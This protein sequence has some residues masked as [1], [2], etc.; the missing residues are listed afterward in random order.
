A[1]RVQLRRHRG[2]AGRRRAHG[3]ALRRRRRPSPLRS[4]SARVSRHLG[5]SGVRALVT[6]VDGVLTDGGLYF[7]EHGDE[8]KRF[9]VR[10]GQG[11]VLLREAGVLVAI[12]TRMPST[13]VTR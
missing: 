8:L 7:G 12:V 6:D 3:P 1:L 13:T 9:D 2:P 10:D 4:V 5:W 11:L